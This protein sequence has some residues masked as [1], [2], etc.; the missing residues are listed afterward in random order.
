MRQL[1]SEEEGP[2]LHINGILN[3]YNKRNDKNGV[4]TSRSV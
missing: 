1:N 2:L 3:D 4:W